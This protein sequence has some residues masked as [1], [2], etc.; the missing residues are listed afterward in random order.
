MAQYDIALPGEKRRD[1]VAGDVTWKARAACKHK[2]PRY[3]HPDP[4]RSPSQRRRGDQKSRSEQ[5][6]TKRAKLV[7]GG[8]PV[9]AECLAYAVVNR[10]DQGVWGG[11]A[12]DEREV[13]IRQSRRRAST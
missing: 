13:L 11:L 8:C 9:Q 6:H 12:W 4:V 3:M 1:R 2:G 5:Y 10:I 7:C